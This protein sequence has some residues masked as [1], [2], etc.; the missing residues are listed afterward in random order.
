VQQQPAPAS[1]NDLVRVDRRRYP[2]LHLIGNLDGHVVPFQIGL[3]LLDINADGFV[4]HAPFE[5]RAGTTHEF[6]FATVQQSRPEVRAVVAQ[7]RP[8]T[9][10][11]GREFFVAGFTFVELSDAARAV[12]DAIVADVDWLSPTKPAVIVPAADLPGLRRDVS[13]KNK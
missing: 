12:I 5:F 10:R 8:V 1:A 3:R 11:R 6:Q 13:I 4:V 2:R 7:S 9:L